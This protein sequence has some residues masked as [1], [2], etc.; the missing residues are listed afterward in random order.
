MRAFGGFQESGI[1]A[2]SP[3]TWAAT[4]RW[5]V[6]QSQCAHCVL[7]R[8][9]YRLHWGRLFCHQGHLEIPP[10]RFSFMVECHQ[11]SDGHMLLSDQGTFSTHSVG[12]QSK[13]SPEKTRRKNLSL[14]KNLDIQDLEEELF[15][16]MSEQVKTLTPKDASWAIWWAPFLVTCQQDEMITTKQAG[17][18]SLF[19]EDQAQHP[20]KQVTSNPPAHPVSSPLFPLP[21]K[22]QNI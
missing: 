11:C 22:I 19:S 5:N 12:L 13:T 21:W 9:R 20:G 8:L 3:N 7:P 16:L 4:H 6:I 2:S 10:S 17:L 1:N 18:V 14:E 15:S